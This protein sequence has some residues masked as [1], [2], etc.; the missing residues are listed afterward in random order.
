[1]SVGET[2]GDAFW[3]FWLTRL[4]LKAAVLFTKY[5]SFSFSSASRTAAAEE[6]GAIQNCG[7]GF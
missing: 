6:C 2:N 5:L 7:L 3:F 1:M 4:M